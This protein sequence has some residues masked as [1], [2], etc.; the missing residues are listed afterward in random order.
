MN[1]EKLKAIFFILIA[2][3]LLSTGGLLL[4]LIDLPPMAIAGSRAVFSTAVVWLYV[5]KPKFTFSKAQ[6]SGAI[7]YSL[8][9]IG[10]IVANKLT[11]A[12]NAILLQYSAPIWVAILGVWILKEK[13]RW[14]D[15]L[16]ILFVAMG[17][18]LFFIDDVEGGNLTGNIVAILSG[19]ALAGVTISLR[20]QKNES[21][22]E[23]T[24]LGHILTAV[25]G[26]PFVIGVTF[27]FIDV[28]G[29][30]LL[31]V[32]QLGIAYIFYSIAIKHL[33]AL[34]AILIMFI[35]P[36]LNPIWVFIVVGERPSFLSLIGGTIVLITIVFR[37]IIASKYESNN[38]SSLI[39]VKV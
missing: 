2:A 18:L 12:A 21:P 1:K 31:G 36:I 4:K 6:V 27:T 10:F 7:C 9:V 29:I 24:M 37:S 14:Y 32:F 17:M 11:T 23:T 13:I 39:K 5:K 15:L 22:V 26:L 25:L 16:S 28:I 19:V 30:F 35:E 34:E 20:F 3:T 33:T 38:N 8:M